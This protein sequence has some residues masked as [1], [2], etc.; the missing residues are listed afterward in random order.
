MPHPLVVML[1]LVGVAL[2]LTQYMGAGRFERV[3]RLV[4]DGS[5]H[6]IPKA[7]DLPALLSLQPAP[8]ASAAR[9][10]PATLGSAALA[11]PAGMVR[12]APLLVMVLF[13]GGM[14]GVLQKTDCLD[15]AIGRLVAGRR[16]R[17]S[18]A[19]A[20]LMGAV[21][22]GATF[23]G[24]MSEYLGVLVL[25]R[26]LLERLGRGP[27]F[28]TAA[29]V[30]AAKVGFLASVTNPLPLLIAQPLVGRDLASG[31]GL[32]LLAFLLFLLPAVAWV[33]YSPWTRAAR[34]TPVAPLPAA[35]LGWRH[36]A[37]LW[38]LAAGVVLLVVG[39]AHW[40]W[41]YTA[42]AAF[43]AALA[44][45]LALPARMDARG[46]CEAFVGGMQAMA[47]PVLLI[48]MAR[49][50]QI[51]LEDSRVLDRAILDLAA[52]AQGRT[53]VTAALGIALSVALL[54]L[55][56][57]STS[58]KAALALPVLAPA[59]QL[60]GVPADS[61]V[62]AFLMGNGLTN[63]LTPTSGLLLAFLAAGGVRYADWLRFV[64]P[65]FLVFVLV[66]M[67]LLA[68]SVRMAG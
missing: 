52:L 5:F 68:A 23:L 42:I 9:A 3:G 45:V 28:A 38:L 12:A 15:A 4:V 21:A 50:V 57:P 6:A 51:L 33:L 59:A 53:A 44:A 30:L 58:G 2:V 65:V 8:A 63:M 11:I 25:V 56:L 31:A 41:G 46:A 20:A 48:G 18:L 17:E 35:P 13:A 19:T 26:G 34:A 1:L 60:A 29:V 40:H 10:Y 22:C 49:A 32:R 62:F 54:G 61:V 27:L 36:G 24:L 7:V 39:T 37:V 47:L 16:G 66:A 43:Y 64:A 14:F 55:L 67:A